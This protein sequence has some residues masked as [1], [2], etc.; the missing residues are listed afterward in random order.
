MCQVRCPPPSCIRS[1]PP[2]VMGGAGG[3]AVGRVAGMQ[4][5]F[6][7]L[8]GGERWIGTDQLDLGDAHELKC[9]CL[10]NPPP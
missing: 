7:R 9:T 6:S 2:V 8:I 10:R 3:R 1:R 5:R 4:A